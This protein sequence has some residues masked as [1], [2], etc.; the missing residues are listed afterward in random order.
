MI[1]GVFLVAMVDRTTNDVG[2]VKLPLEF[3]AKLISN[4][5]DPRFSSTS[6]VVGP[7]N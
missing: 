7:V 5:R 4:Y 1:N 2:S 3:K 6:A